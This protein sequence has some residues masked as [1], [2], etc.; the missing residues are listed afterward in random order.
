ML[1]LTDFI[2]AYEHG[3]Y[4]SELVILQAINNLC[5]SVTAAEIETNKA[6]LAKLA[7]M[8]HTGDGSFFG[9][10]TKELVAE[11]FLEET[12]LDNGK[13]GYTTSDKF[14][15]FFND[16]ERWFLELI[17]NYPTHDHYNKSLVPNPSAST[18]TLV[19]TYYE[20]VKGDKSRHNKVMTFLKDN[21]NRIKADSIDLTRF[22]QDINFE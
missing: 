15:E 18:M 4:P 21:L 20:L 1:K 16:K 8:N 9:A 10:K 2:L 19:N 11:G 14:K 13:K 6:I 12:T 7:T 22:I 17:S 3:I 5:K